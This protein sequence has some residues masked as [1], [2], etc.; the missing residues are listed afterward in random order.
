MKATCRSLRS[1]ILFLALLGAVASQTPSFAP[2]VQAAETNLAP[3]AAGQPDDEAAAWNEVQAAGRPL[4]TPP[5]WDETPPS[6]AERNAFL[7]KAA[8]AQAAAADKA[9]AFIQRFPK[10]DRVGTARKLQ[11]R[12]LSA[13]V[14]YGRKDRADELAK[15]Q[16][17]AATDTTLPEAERVNARLQQLNATARSLASTDRDAALKAFVD[18]LIAMQK[19]FPKSE[20]VY[21]IMMT[22]ARNEEGD[23]RK[24]LCQVIADSPDAPEKL[25]KSAQD[26][27]DNKVFEAANHIGKPVDIKFTALDG[28]EVD[29]AKMKGKVVLIDFWA[30]WCGPCVAE[31][32]NV[33]AAYEKYHAQG[34]EILG[35]SFDREG[36]KEKLIQ[37][38][39]DKGMTWP[40]AFDGKG[41]ESDF[42]QRFNI[43]GI[44]TMWLIGKDGNLASANARHDLAGQVAKLL[45]AK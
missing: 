29:L 31:I 28:T 44:P 14:A 43:Q 9:T 8:N 26:I 11:L 16:S 20:Q 18:G 17:A 1:Q 25:K 35:I 32:P 23:L 13:A 22:I 7:A 39:K 33:K 5:E 30:T 27:L 21:G 42:A 15:L 41:W 34:F 3:A 45:E 36:D 12:T 40:Q 2:V 6:E 10:S 38:T 24:K 19:D 4:R 37:F